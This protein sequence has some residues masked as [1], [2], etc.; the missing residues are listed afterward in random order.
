M[1]SLC[2]LVNKSA[3]QYI[4]LFGIVWTRFLGIVGYPRMSWVNQTDSKF[5]GVGGY[6]AWWQTDF[7]VAPEFESSSSGYRSEIQYWNV[8]LTTVRLGQDSHRP[9]KSMYRKKFQYLHDIDNDKTIYSCGSF[10]ITLI[11]SKSEKNGC[12]HHH[13]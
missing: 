3:F 4:V 1:F 9:L 11:Y 12:N 2:F 6:G 8:T 13:L 5:R 10:D 7:K